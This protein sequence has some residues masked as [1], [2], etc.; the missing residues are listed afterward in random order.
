MSISFYDYMIDEYYDEDS[1]FGD[2]VSDMQFDE[3]FDESETDT[4]KL[5]QYFQSRTK[6]YYVM[7]VVEKSLEAYSKGIYI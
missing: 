4:E 7:N 2:L 1:E 6:N 3:Y 5:L